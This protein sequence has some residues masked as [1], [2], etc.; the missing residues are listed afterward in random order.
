LTEP[1]L[2]ELVRTRLGEGEAVVTAMLASETCTEAIAAA[3]EQIAAAASAGR[4][5]LLFGNG[6]SAAD[7]VHIAAEFVGRYLVER[8]P[9]PA[10]ALNANIS[11]LTAIG[12]DYGFEQLFSRQVGALGQTGDVAVGLS[13]SGR[14]PNVVA[15]LEEA[16][17]LGLRTIAMT[18]AVPGPVGEAAELTIAIPSEETP[19][20][21]E[22]HMLAAHTICE[23]VEAA[24]AEGGSR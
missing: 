12:N 7:A 14:S 3:A 19:R 2:T 21:Q 11:A 23:W 8:R 1:K 18:G 5:V 15:G 17:K 16:G 6:G 13:T 22:G 24:I 20:I 9:L 10:L 4:K